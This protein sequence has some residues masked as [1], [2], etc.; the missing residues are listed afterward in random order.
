M[1]FVTLGRSDSLGDAP[2]ID[3]DFEGIARRSVERLYSRGHRRIAVAVPKVEANLGR[4]FMQGY[5]DGLAS[6]GLSFDSELVFQAETSEEGGYEVADQLLKMPARPTAILLNAELMSVGLY[7]RLGEA[8]LTPGHDLAIIAERE[9]PV[10]RFL[11]PR[12]TCFRLN[13]DELGRTLGQM[14]LA[15]LPAFAE[16]YA[17]LPQ[18]KIWPLE[19][20]EGESDPPL[21]H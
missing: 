1:P 6:C 2:W 5:S 8:G 21:N 3:L 19:L 11:L 15:S 9:S 10:G 13:L 17:A 4:L 14:L 20:A 12:L 7:R 18:Q 16:Q